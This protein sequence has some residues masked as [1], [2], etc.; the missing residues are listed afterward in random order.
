[1]AIR[2]RALLVGVTLGRS[3]SLAAEIVR[4]KHLNGDGYRTTPGTSGNYTALA[5]GRVNGLAA[6]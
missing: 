4:Q 1:M 2:L 6:G 5:A 3:D